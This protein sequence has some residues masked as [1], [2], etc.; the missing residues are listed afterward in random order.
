MNPLMASQPAVARNIAQ[1]RRDGYYVAEPGLAREH[2]NTSDGTLAFG[3]VGI[4]PRLLVPLLSAVL[5]RNG[6]TRTIRIDT[7]QHEKIAVVTSE[8]LGE[9]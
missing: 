9:T 6:E 7:D 2:S 5:F 1:L 8:G 4:L 3:G